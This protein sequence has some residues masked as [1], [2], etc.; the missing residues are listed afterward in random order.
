VIAGTIL[1]SVLLVPGLLVRIF[2]GEPEVLAVGIP[3]LRFFAVFFFIEV[4]GYSF[5]I[6][7]T[8]NGWGSYVLVSE[9]LTNVLFILGLTFLLTRVYGLGIYAAWLSFALYQVFH[10]LILLRGYLSGR[11]LEVR[12]D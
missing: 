8:G 12:L 10:A 4:L 9:F 5:E 1:L 11:W 7:F 2:S 6:V 3:A